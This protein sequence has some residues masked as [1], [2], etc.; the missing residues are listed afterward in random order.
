MVTRV[1]PLRQKSHCKKTLTGKLNWF[2]PLPEVPNGVHP[3]P[4][5]SSIRTMRLFDSSAT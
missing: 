2:G 1:L 5:M 4:V 3:A